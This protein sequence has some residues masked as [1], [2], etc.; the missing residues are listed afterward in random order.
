M[1][2]AT[3]LKHAA[4]VLQALTVVGFIFVIIFDAVHVTRPEHWLGIL[5]FFLLPILTQVLLCWFLRHPIIHVSSIIASCLILLLQA[6]DLFT[7][8]YVPAVL[9]TLPATVI[10]LFFG[11]VVFFLH[12]WLTRSTKRS[13]RAQRRNGRFDQPDHPSDS[14]PTG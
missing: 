9:L 10:V 5:C 8:G 14:P 7:R 11:T 6:S 4:T 1:S 13:R 12:H 2:A 3:I